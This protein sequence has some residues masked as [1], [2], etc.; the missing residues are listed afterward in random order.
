MTKAKKS[1]KEVAFEHRRDGIGVVESARALSVSRKTIQRWRAQGPGFPCKMLRPQRRKLT[2]SQEEAVLAFVAERPGQFQDQIVEFVLRTFGIQIS[3]QTVSNIL[4]RNDV[5]RK[6]G[7]RVNNK[8]SVDKGMQFLEE[9]RDLNTPLIASLDE[10][11]VMLNLAPTHGYAPRGRRAVIPQPSRR[12]V[13]YMLTL[14]ICPVGILYWNLRSGTI[15]AEIFSETLKKLPDGITLLL[16]NA[17]VH[18]ASKCL[19][20]KNLPTV[21]EIVAS[22]SL[23][24]KYI[25]PYA[26]HL[27]P[28]E[29]TFNTVRNL[30]KRSEAWTEEK[31]KQQLASL[32]KSDSFSAD[33]LQKLFRSVREG[34]PNPG[35]RHKPD[36]WHSDSINSIC[37][38]WSKSQCKTMPNELH[39]MLS[40]VFIEKYFP[41]SYLWR[42]DI[43]SAWI[44]ISDKFKPQQEIVQPSSAH[45]TCSH[46]FNTFAV[47]KHDAYVVSLNTESKPS[48]APFL[49]NSERLALLIANATCA[50]YISSEFASIQWAA[51][52]AASM[53]FDCPPSSMKA[54]IAAVVPPSY[55]CHKK[56]W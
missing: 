42:Y 48:I 11:S 40:N 7:S 10:M 43:I 37:C 28:V 32:F 47:A 46:P 4:K 35:Q 19:S 1:A 30:L 33:S 54:L 49:S 41:T 50:W 2:P 53:A 34:G 3:Q 15:D 18:H 14:V 9:F 44:E 36:V 55:A 12:T 8:C 22:K 24:L 45:L 31:L 25:P 21:A 5:T 39:K 26:P 52:L 27:N 51:L 56:V 23:T 29:Y 17:R 16:D 6:R 13:S 20:D 38:S